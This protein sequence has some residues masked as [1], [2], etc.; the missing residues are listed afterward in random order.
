MTCIYE[1]DH[2]I[3]SL[4]LT[5]CLLTV[6]I[7][8]STFLFSQRLLPELSDLGDGPAGRG[9]VAQPTAE[10]RPRPDLRL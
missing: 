10:P 2:D 4:W 3:Q 8:K 7:D 6:I 1:E 5:V 9:S